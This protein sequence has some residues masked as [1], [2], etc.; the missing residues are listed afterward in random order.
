M[1]SSELL[2]LLR[3]PMD[4]SNTRLEAADTSLICQRCRVHFPIR[5]G[6][7]CLLI[8]EAQLPEGCAGVDALPC[9]RDRQRK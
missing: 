6:I 8:E 1:I 5:D 7:P 3:C 4:P 2:E 9:Q